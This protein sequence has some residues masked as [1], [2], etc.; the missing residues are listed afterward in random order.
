MSGTAPYVK[1]SDTSQDAAESME[2]HLAR[3][4]ETIFSLIQNSWSGIMSNMDPQLGWTDDE[5]ERWLGLP[6]QTVS[7]R[8]RELVLKGLIEDS[9]ERRK[10][11]SGRKAVVWV[12]KKTAD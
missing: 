3:L 2:P 1:G 5:L 6:H 4:Q 10:T 12:L 7:A 9:G 8:R 11:R